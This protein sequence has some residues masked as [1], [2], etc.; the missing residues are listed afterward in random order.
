[1]QTPLGN[2]SSDSKTGG[3]KPLSVVIQRPHKYERKMPPGAQDPGKFKEI[4]TPKG[5]MSARPGLRMPSRS[6][7]S[8][9][10]F[11]EKPLLR[12]GSRPDIIRRPN[13]GMLRFNGT[14][15][16]AGGGRIG[17]YPLKKPTG[18]YPAEGPRAKEPSV[19]SGL[20]HPKT[21]DSTRAL[22][23]NETSLDTGSKES[24]NRSQSGMEPIRNVVKDGKEP[25][26]QGS[27]ESPDSVKVPESFQNMSDSSEEP[28]EP[29]ITTEKNL[30]A[31]INGT[32]CVRKVL[33]GHRR[34]HFNGSS[35]GK[36]VTKNMT[37][38][39]GHINGNEIVRNLLLSRSEGFAKG[40]TPL[41]G[42]RTEQKPFVERTSWEDTEATSEGEETGIINVTSQPTSYSPETFTESLVRGSTQHEEAGTSRSR[43]SAYST[44][45]PSLPPAIPVTL[46]VLLPSKTQNKPANQLLTERHFNRTS[47]KMSLSSRNRYPI[48]RTP[49]GSATPGQRR[50]PNPLEKSQIL[51]DR[52]SNRNS[53]SA[54]ISHS[55]P[56]TSEREPGGSKESNSDGRGLLT[57]SI[58]GHSVAPSLTKLPLT[59]ISTDTE[60]VN[61]R[62]EVGKTES[63]QQKVRNKTL[64][65]F[66][67]TPF[68]GGTFLRQPFQ[69]RTRLI[70]KPPL[71]PNRSPILR[72]ELPKVSDRDNST[73]G[74]SGAPNQEEPEINSS[75][76]NRLKPKAPFTLRRKNGAI[77]RFPPNLQRE[78]K[79]NATTFA[80]GIQ[81]S[82]QETRGSDSTV[83][84]SSDED[85]STAS[86]IGLKADKYA[87]KDSRVTLTTDKPAVKTNEESQ[88]A[89]RTEHILPRDKSKA[90]QTAPH[91]QVLPETIS[92]LRPAFT[93]RR[94]NGTFVKPPTKDTH[95][96]PKATLTDDSK[97]E[98]EPKDQEP[99]LG[100]SP[101]KSQVLLA[102]K[103]IAE[104][105]AA[106]S[107]SEGSED[108]IDHVGVQ[109]VS[110]KGFIVVW[111]APKGMFQNFVM[112]V[113]E[114]GRGRSGPERKEEDG[115]K[116]DRGGEEDK[117]GDGRR[118]EA[119]VHGVAPGSHAA[120]RNISDGGATKKF[121]IMLPGSTRSYPATDLNPQTGYSVS[122]FGKGPGFRSNIYS[123][124]IRTGTQNRTLAAFHVPLAF[125]T[126]LCI[127][128]MKLPTCQFCVC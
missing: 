13:V 14:R 11:K 41:N 96:K 79:A 66:P 62:S 85:A 73:V 44:P 52:Q 110:S 16:G 120:M 37:V 86:R 126:T 108:G 56:E 1:M 10:T 28:L 104:P 112:S 51:K 69:N 45:P 83:S 87:K 114:H 92:S 12:P 22:D 61:G 35:D 77:I 63:E 105:K 27:E 39:I 118:K 80:R 115:D 89:D 102:N 106:F 67:R 103:T 91:D 2:Y 7:Q 40:V 59:D 124:I 57:E 25:T 20:E 74:P 82:T 109:N 32:K 46:P 50:R 88:G 5:N 3:T 49:P 97:D 42:E 119:G 24:I 81:N 15:T 116:R 65:L 90:G 71:H 101:D 55:V 70:L 30:T 23:R 76:Q 72:P 68:R 100:P 113:G 19:W 21:G 38:I 58:H 75:T 48:V 17:S 4:S 117:A 64:P 9:P 18:M 125:E 123:F 111:G 29:T 93:I 6:G 121:T 43:G 128:A 95:A 53:H 127:S 34:I 84:L 33:V 60:G 98:K 94:K 36:V 99:K 122:L 107:L 78:M 26:T 31:H 47:P 54:P 8:K